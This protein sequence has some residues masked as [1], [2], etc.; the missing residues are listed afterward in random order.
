MVAYRKLVFQFHKGTIK[1][2]KGQFEKGRAKTFQFHKGT[3]KTCY[4]NQ[5]QP[6][7]FRIS[8]P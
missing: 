5:C 6:K 4:E 8:I 2:T 7:H 1:T 3:I